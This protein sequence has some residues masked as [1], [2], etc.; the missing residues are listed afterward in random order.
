MLSYDATLE[1]LNIWPIDTIKTLIERSL[2]D[3]SPILLCADIPN[4]VFFLLLDNGLD[5]TAKDSN[6]QFYISLIASKWA[7]L[8]EYLETHDLQ[9]DMSVKDAQ[10]N[11]FLMVA[12]TLS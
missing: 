7:A 12:T 11:T 4:N 9:I 3:V 1:I 5:V 8:S 2:L 10:G 6:G